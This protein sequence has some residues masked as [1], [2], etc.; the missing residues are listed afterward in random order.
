[1]NRLEDPAIVRERYRASMAGVEITLIV[2]DICRL[3]PG[4]EGIRARITVYSIVGRFLE[5]SRIYYFHDD[6]T[7][8]YYSSQ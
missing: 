8:R 6:A 5:H 3:R 2:R 1:M 7:G 4:I